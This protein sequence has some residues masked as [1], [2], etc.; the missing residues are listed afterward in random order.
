MVSNKRN[1][2]PKLN[3]QNSTFSHNPSRGGF[4]IVDAEADAEVFDGVGIELAIG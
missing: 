2:N 1:T 3:I 4:S